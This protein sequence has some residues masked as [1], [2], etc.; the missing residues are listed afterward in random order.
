MKKT[1][2]TIFAAFLFGT[3]AVCAQTTMRL[4]SIIV[5]TIDGE[6]QKNECTAYDSNGNLELMTVYDWDNDLDMWKINSKTEYAYNSNGNENQT[7][8]YNWDNNLN[9][10]VKYAKT[11]VSYDE[12]NQ[13]IQCIEYLWNG[14][15]WNEV[16]VIDY[17]Y[18]NTGKQTGIIYD[19]NHNIIYGKMETVF[20]NTGQLSNIHFY[21][22]SGDNEWSPYFKMEYACD[23]NG[24]LISGTQYQW[25]NHLNDWTLFYTAVYYYNPTP[26]ALS[27][28][29]AKKEILKEEYY[30]INGKPTTPVAKGIV[31][32]RIIYTD[33]TIEVV[34]ELK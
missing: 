25:D 31:I 10:W 19:E 1:M 15:A 9:D 16:D 24:N 13:A 3:A 32:K 21:L 11:E 28:V 23:E 22:S 12:S 20:N 17:T 4:D 14:Y 2:T 33:N 29:S 5:E 6:K 8:I 18:D 34:K 7:A 30:T 27:A 26:A